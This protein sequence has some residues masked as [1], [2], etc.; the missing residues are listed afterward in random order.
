MM[1]DRNVHK[2]KFDTNLKRRVK[3]FWEAQPLNL[4]LTTCFKKFLIIQNN[5]K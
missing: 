3:S 2:Y 4:R 5:I 1:K